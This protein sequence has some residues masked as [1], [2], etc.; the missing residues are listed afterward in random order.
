MLGLFLPFK[1]SFICAVDAVLL[2]K[3]FRVFT[4]IQ[5]MV[6]A[7]TKRQMHE[8]LEMKEEEIAQLRSRIKQMTTQGEE[9][10][11]Q[12]EKSER[13]GKNLRVTCFM[14]ELKSYLKCLTS[15]FKK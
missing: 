8:T 11:E 9:L 10:R 12:K 6:I 14:L 15:I 2:C 7:E 4:S 3:C 5:G 1:L 13:A